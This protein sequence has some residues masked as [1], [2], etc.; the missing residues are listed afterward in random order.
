MGKVSQNS[1]NY[2]IKAKLNSSGIIEKSDVVGAVFGQTE[3]LLG[4]DL[5]LRELR[6]K[7]KVGRI[8]VD[9]KKNSGSTEGTIEIATS[10]DAT[11]TSILAASLE[12]IEKIG[13]T[14]ADIRVEEVSDVRSSKRDYIIKRSKQ[15]LKDIRS[16]NP[17]MNKIK[18]EVKH[19][20]RESEIVNF[21]GFPAGPDIYFSDEVILVEGQA[22]VKNLV[23]H[24]VKNALALGGTSVPDKIPEVTE[25]KEVTAF[26]DGDRGGDLILEELRDRMEVDY[27]VRAPE[28]KEVE[29]LD[30]R[31][32]FE[33]LRDKEDSQYV[34]ETE[35][36]EEQVAE[37]DLE[38]F[39]EIM[40]ELVA[41]RA[42]N[43]VDEDYEV[44]DRMPV[45]KKDGVDAEQ[46]Y[47][48]LADDTVD[49]DLVNLAEQLEAQYVI[50]R[51]K[52]ATVNSSEV[53][54]I[55][56]EDM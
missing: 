14:R 30:E 12:T 43:V 56:E 47:A 2:M 40:N 29:E 9:L 50:G 17:D 6:N 7:G 11:D 35:S 34:E 48:V 15:I 46:A 28:G 42:L 36:D 20:V 25:D 41:T 26:L 49:S 38:A 16:E 23:K 27:V 44:T 18:E 55:T 33:A 54:I 10:L 37:E 24:G 19:E 51:D 13:P 39:N 32:T 45:D 31:Q 52:T 3:G 22:D 8:E 53:K 1:A 4:E 21:R 5:D